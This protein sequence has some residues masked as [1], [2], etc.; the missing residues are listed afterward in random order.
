MERKSA[1]VEGLSLQQQLQQG[2][3]RGLSSPWKIILGMVGTTL[4]GIS[5]SSKNQWEL[6]I[7]LTEKKNGIKSHFLR[8]SRVC[9]PQRGKAA[10]KIQ[11]DDKNLCFHQIPLI[12]VQVHKRCV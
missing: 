11:E 8:T 1:V 7:T 9:V 2:F 4:G 5:T 10:A 6:K 12:P 3:S